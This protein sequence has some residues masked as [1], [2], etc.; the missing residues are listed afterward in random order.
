LLANSGEKN[1]NYKAEDDLNGE[2]NPSDSSK[3]S[4]DEISIS[5]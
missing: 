5:L 3:N 4:Q 1:H 2:A